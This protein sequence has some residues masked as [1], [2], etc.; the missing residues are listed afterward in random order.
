MVR[1]EGTD[2]SKGRISFYADEALTKKITKMEYTGE[3]ITPYVKV[4]V[5]E[6]KV[7]KVV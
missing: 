2:L 5:K 4:E 7:W 6:G 3:E 1:K